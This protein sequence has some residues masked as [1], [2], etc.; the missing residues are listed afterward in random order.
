LIAAYF[1]RDPSH[2]MNNHVAVHQEKMVLEHR[3]QKEIGED[4]LKVPA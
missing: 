3:H 1:V 4:G 2:L